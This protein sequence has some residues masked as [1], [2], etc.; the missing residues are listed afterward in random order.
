MSL[1]V[2]ACGA[3]NTLASAC[4]V[5][6]IGLGG[7]IWRKNVDKF[8]GLAAVS[9]HSRLELADISHLLRCMPCRCSVAVC[10][11]LLPP[12]AGPP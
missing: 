6:V 10:A 3:L 7:F 12:E 8:Q 5:P 4:P 11:S 1:H 9:S 2:A